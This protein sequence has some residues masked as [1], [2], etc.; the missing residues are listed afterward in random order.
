[1]WDDVDPEGAKALRNGARRSGIT[2]GRRSLEVAV[3]RHDAR[4]VNA[5]SQC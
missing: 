2:A 5:A 4:G 1:M 3:E